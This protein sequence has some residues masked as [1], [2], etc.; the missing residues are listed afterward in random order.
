M[1][2]CRTLQRPSYGNDTVCATSYHKADDGLIVNLNFRSNFK[3]NCGLKFVFNLSP[4][5]E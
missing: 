3:L 2:K 4:V 1:S 5:L